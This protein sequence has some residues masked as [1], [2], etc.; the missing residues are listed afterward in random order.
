MQMAF[1]LKEFQQKSW[2][3]KVTAF[4]KSIDTK[5]YPLS[6][7][8]LISM[9]EHGSMESRLVEN[10]ET[11]SF[12][13]FPKRRVTKSLYSGTGMLFV[14][15][16]EQH[17]E[18]I[19]NLMSTQFK[20]IPTWQFEDVMGSLSYESASCGAHF[21]QYDVFLLQHTGTK[22]WLFDD[23]SHI[24]EDL[25][26]NT[27]L[28]LLKNFAPT[29]EIIANEGDLI[30]VPPGTGHHGIS[31][32]LSITLS[33]GIR[34][35]TP[36]EIL[37][38]LSTHVMSKMGNQVPASSKLFSGQAGISDDFVSEIRQALE[39]AL[40]RENTEDWIGIFST[41]LKNPDLLETSDSEK[42]LIGSSLRATLP[43][44]FAF[45]TKETNVLFFVNGE[46]YILD[47]SDTNWIFELVTE[48]QF[49]YRE[50]MSF[51]GENCI[52]EMIRDGS[53]S[54]VSAHE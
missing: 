36:F 52:S 27:E 2:R 29:S 37:G 48:R 49:V 10:M 42:P 16:L 18:I 45:K 28:R 24:D 25:M 41:L 4:K 26:E 1:P 23:G 54:V 13:P 50:N 30:Y 9:A 35:P 19:R 47:L 7:D 15:G 5:G 8:E 51:S 3:K 43:S 17:L 6:P 12:G 22:Q 11:V 39:E 46:R 21:D 31:K 32:N 53:L 38:D 44:R 33:I 14:Q 34:N 20:F 40:T